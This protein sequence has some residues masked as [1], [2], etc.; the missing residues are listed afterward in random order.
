MALLRVLFLGLED[1]QLCSQ[2]TEGPTSYL[3][4]GTSVDTIVISI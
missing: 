3:C 2:I 1:K 4:F